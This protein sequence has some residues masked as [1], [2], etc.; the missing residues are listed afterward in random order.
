ML[1]R[2]SGQGYINSS[3]YNVVDGTIY[4]APQL[5]TVFSARV[6]MLKTR[7]SLLRQISQWQWHKTFTPLL[8]LKTGSNTPY[9]R[10]K[11]RQKSKSYLI[12]TF[13]QADLALA[14]DCNRG[15]LCRNGE[16]IDMSQDYK[17]IYLP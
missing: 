8:F 15:V 16:A 6:L 13:L 3:V 10:K 4:K 12:N 5:C 1:L 7:T 11:R 9:I 2:S 14:E 17:P